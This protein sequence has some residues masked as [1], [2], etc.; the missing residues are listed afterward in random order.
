[1]R[2]TRLAGRAD[3]L[4]YDCRGH[5]GS[6]RG[7]TDYTTELFAADLAGLLDRIGW[8][9]AVVAGCSMGGCV[10]QDFAASNPHRTDG[11][12]LVDTT[13]WYGPTAPLDWAGRAAKAREQGLAALVDFQVTRWFGAEF[14][15]GEPELVAALTKTFLANDLDSYAATCRM[16]GAADLRER[17]AAVRVPAAVVVG[18]DDAATPVP[19][20][21]DLAERL[22]GAPLTVL[23][24][25]RHLTPLERPTEIAAVIQELVANV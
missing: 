14:A 21:E 12:V 13:A 3:V 9:R 16:L 10:A 25:S 11:L 23:P 8:D 5:G 22:G 2:N 17:V 18:E 20:A 6:D 15:A 4:S 7:G 19:M 1:M 24:E